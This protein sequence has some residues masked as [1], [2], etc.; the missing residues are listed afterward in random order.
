MSEKEEEHLPKLLQQLWFWNHLFSSFDHLFPIMRPQ[1]M[2]AE[3]AQVQSS[4]KVK[5]EEVRN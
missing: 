4:L 5:K 2:K 3:A 1:I